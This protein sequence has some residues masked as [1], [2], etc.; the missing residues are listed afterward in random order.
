LRLPWP[1]AA[2]AI[3]LM[4][5]SSRKCI[6]ANYL[7]SDE[8]TYSFLILFHS[9]AYV[10]IPIIDEI[11][12]MCQMPADACLLLVVPNPNYTKPRP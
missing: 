4:Q 11:K 2:A 9:F 1:R 10:G 12:L 7:I 6:S 3:W 5:V 8:K